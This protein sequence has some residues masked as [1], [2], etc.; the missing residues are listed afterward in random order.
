[1]EG[2]KEKI[3]IGQVIKNKRI[4]H[5]FTQ[6]Q[7]ANGIGLSRNYLSDIENGRYIPSV[8]TLSRLASYLEIDLNFLLKMTE[9]QDIRK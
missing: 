9:I 4:K 8:I 3:Y 2:N 7:V 6:K 1:M 5:N